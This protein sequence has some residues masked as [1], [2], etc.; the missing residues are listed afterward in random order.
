MT[1]CIVSFLDPCCENIIK[2]TPSYAANDVISEYSRINPFANSGDFYGDFN[3]VCR[4]IDVDFGD[5]RDFGV[6]CVGFGLFR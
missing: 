3:G 2:L 6:N 1:S 4:D 5:F